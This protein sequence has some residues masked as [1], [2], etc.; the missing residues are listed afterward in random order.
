MT[1]LFRFIALALALSAAVSPIRAAERAVASVPAAIELSGLIRQSLPALSPAQVSVPS[2]SRDAGSPA[3][4]VVPAALDTQ[5]AEIIMRLAAATPAATA[6][7]HDPRSVIMAVNSVLRDF[8]PERLEKLSPA[9]LHG[10]SEVILENMQGRTPKLSDRMA[11]LMASAS[12]E[13]MLAQRGSLK[14][15]LL[16]PNHNDMHPDLISVRGLPQEARLVLPAAEPEGPKTGRSRKA[17]PI[18]QGTVFRHYRPEGRVDGILES[19]SLYSGIVPYV[20]LSPGTFRKTFKDVNGLFFTLPG[21][22]GDDVGVPSK[23]FKGYVDVL[24][25]A[26]LP[27]LELE[28]G[29]IYLVPLPGRARDWVRDYYMKWVRGEEVPS[30]YHDM[31]SDLDA[32]GGPGPNVQV[33]IKIVRHGKVR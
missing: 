2:L 13:R 9:D 29:L 21:V 17:K 24:L 11:V 31:I 12:A 25:T 32:E 10:L 14:E 6:Q 15:K 33:P 16:N 30:V 1:R 27:L 4:L 8:T 5:K 3:A 18:E 23:D 26:G 7:A 22:K 19:Q 20:Q 28:P